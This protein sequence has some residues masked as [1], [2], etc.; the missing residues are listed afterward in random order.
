MS[1]SRPTDTGAPRPEELAAYVDGQLAPARRKGVEIW[2]RNHPEAAVEIEEQRRLAGLW[3]ATTPGEPEE[4]N[5]GSILTHVEGAYGRFRSA[6]S[7]NR[8]LILIGAA[9]LAA[10]LLL[11]LRTPRAGEPF[12]VV[13][14]DDVEIVSLHAAD[15]V[16]LV[17]GVPPVTE[18]LVLASLGDVEL[19]GV[20]P[21]ADG[22]LP[23]IHMDER[24]TTPMIVAPLDA[25]QAEAPD[26]SPK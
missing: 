11:M 4:A 23:S 9:G 13:S 8:R 10:G 7:R 12:A 15:R 2:L 19:E 1:R 24:S 14:P 22:M 21:A 3:R 20:E 18:P 16:T 17:V 25:A 5:W 6:R 26:N